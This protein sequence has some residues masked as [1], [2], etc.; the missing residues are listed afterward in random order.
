MIEKTI[1]MTKEEFDRAVLEGWDEGYSEGYSEGYENGYNI[2]YD[3]GSEGD[4]L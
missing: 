2:G 4:D 3:E 1:T